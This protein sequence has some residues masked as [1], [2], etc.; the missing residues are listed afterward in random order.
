MTATLTAPAATPAAVPSADGQACLWC[1]S[2]RLELLYTGVPDRL[3]Y[4]P[5][6]RTWYRCTACQSAV[7]VP[8]PTPEELPAFYPPVYSF[9]LELGQGSLFRR[10]L[11]WFEYHFFFRPM[12]I[13]EVKA[14]AKYAGGGGKGKR[15]LD[16][17]CGRGLRLL[18]FRKLGYDIHGLDI[19][20]DVCR[21]LTDELNIPAVC[22]DVGD[23][24]QFHPPESFDLVTAFFL[25]EHIQDVHAFLR[26]AARVLK[27][28]GVIAL[29][30]PFIDSW[31]AQ[32]F[33]KNWIN[34]TEAPR[35]LSLPTQA[36]I[37]TALTTCGFGDVKVIP[38]ALLN[39][40][41]GFASSAVSGATLT[42]AYGGKD[43]FALVRRAWGA[44]VMFASLPFSAAEN[45]SAG[46]PALAMACGRKPVA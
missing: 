4:V 9:T 44:A 42:H 39:C 26:C 37:R 31:Q 25:G 11:T 33:K 20:A 35:H 3:G 13:Q 10:A 36:G 17:G 41:G 32:L 46:K 7:L 1:Q 18:E 5:G 24:D 29:G 8:L 45:F 40:S 19:Q 43:P 16:I 14:V 30:L 2:D 28:G 15:L 34:I 21:Y 6:T 12:Y 22:A 27:P 38:D 23:I